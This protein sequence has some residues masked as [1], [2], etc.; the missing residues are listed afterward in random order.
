MRMK[1]ISIKDIACFDDVTFPLGS[2]VC[3]Q[4]KNRAGKSALLSCLK[5][6]FERGH[7]PD[8]CLVDEKVGEITIEFDDATMIR[9]RV[10]KDKTERMYKPAGGKKWARSREFIDSMAN[11]LSFDP[12][13]FLQMKDHEQVSEVLR[14]M[15]IEI[16]PEEIADAVKG[17]EMP[18]LDLAGRSALECLNAVYEGIYSA[19]TEAN[20]GADTLEKH[21]SELTLALQSMSVDGTDWDGEVSRLH[22]NLATLDSEEAHLR[23]KLNAEVRQAISEASGQCSKLMLIREQEVEAQIAKLR[24]QLAEYKGDC[25]YSASTIIDAKKMECRQILEA[26]VSNRSEQR[27]AITS[28]IA[29]ATQSRDAS[30]KAKSTQNA[31]TAA[32][33]EA[34]ARREKQMAMTTALDNLKAL[35]A[36]VA[37]RLPLPCTIADGRICREESG[38]LVPLRKWNEASKYTF[39][40]KL[41]TM[42]HGTVGFIVID[43]AGF[44]AFDPAHKK[45]FLASARK[46]AQDEGLQFIVATVSEGPLRVSEV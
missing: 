3:V 2:I 27:T 24:A 29:T 25:Q 30:V 31:I 5:Y 10:G 16:A 26:S 37:S 12:L 45:A 34:V 40:L 36:T 42:C 13:A 18:S 4:G 11:S 19:R 21:A 28:A 14:I 7:D 33:A 35:K 38:A 32:K 23:E 6:S 41:A 17:V 15:P 39:V 20:V 8:M 1:S 44:D 46:Y 43:S 22:K 9:T